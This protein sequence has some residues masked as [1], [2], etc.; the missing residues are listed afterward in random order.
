M[1]DNPTTAPDDQDDVTSETAKEPTSDSTTTPEP[2]A[3]EDRKDRDKKAS[4]DD[5]DQGKKESTE[6]ED[7]EENSVAYAVI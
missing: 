2:K 3:T 7:G 6:D 5:E 4:K 1:P